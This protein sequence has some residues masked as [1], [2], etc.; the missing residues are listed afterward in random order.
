MLPPPAAPDPDRMLRYRQLCDEVS[1][2][3][4][5]INVAAGRLI[6]LARYA[7][8]EGQTEGT[9]IRSAA[10]WVAWRTGLSL[11]HAKDIVHL[12]KRADQLPCCI[13]AL[14]AGELTL[15]QAAVIAW[16]VPTEYAEACTRF[17]KVATVS[18][19]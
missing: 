3:M 13:A 8:E 7:I 6:E 16:H 4:G 14:T 10:H 12:A 1:V 2:V 9:G 15:D 11:R 18:Q 19:L 17:A 5:A